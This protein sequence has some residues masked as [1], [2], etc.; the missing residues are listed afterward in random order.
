M[1][2]LLAGV[3]M[4]LVL[5]LI[6]SDIL[7]RA[8][9]I[10]Y[11]GFSKYLSD[12]EESHSEDILIVD[13]DENSLS[14]YGPYNEW[15]RETH[16][17]V[18]QNLEKGGAAAIAFDILFKNADFGNRNARRTEKAN[19]RNQRGR[20]QQNIGTVVDGLCQSLLLPRAEHGGHQNADARG[21]TVADGKDQKIY[22][23][24][25]ADAA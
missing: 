10:F 19:Q 3:I 22:G 24:R 1:A 11:D 4:T 21:H 5:L 20:A 16:A 14:K 12:H 15:T 2:G 13:I 6:P 9:Y 23:A 18:V 7:H 25:T 17:K 8:E